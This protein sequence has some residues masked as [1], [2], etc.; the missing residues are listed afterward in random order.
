M[1]A[2][3]R[4]SQWMLHLHAFWMIPSDSD[5]KLVRLAIPWVPWDEVAYFRFSNHC[6]PWN[7]QF[8]TYFSLFWTPFLDPFWDCITDPLFSTKKFR[9]AIFVNMELDLTRSQVPY[10]PGEREILFCWRLYPKAFSVPPDLL[11]LS[12]SRQAAGKFL[13]KTKTGVPQ[14]KHGKKVLNHFFVYLHA[15]P[16]K[17]FL[18]FF[19]RKLKIAQKNSWIILRPPIFAEKKEARWCSGPG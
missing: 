4:C 13:C 8:Y 19:C 9:D 18:L 1:R 14:K 12:T 7:P 6:E 17:F 16:A 3:A 11:P 2:R 5:R 15:R 10:S